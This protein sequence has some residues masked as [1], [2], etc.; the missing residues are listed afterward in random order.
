MNKKVILKETYSKKY[1]TAILTFVC[2][3]WFKKIDDLFS[4]N[5]QSEDWKYKKT[6]KLYNFEVIF[7]ISLLVIGLLFSIKLKL[8]LLQLLYNPIQYNRLKM[9]LVKRLDN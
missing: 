4:T 7:F 2:V 3:H 8:L 9:L 5:Y 6:Y 1:Y